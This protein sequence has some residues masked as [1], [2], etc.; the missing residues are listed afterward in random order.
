MVMRNKENDTQWRRAKL[1]AFA[2]RLNRDV[3][4]DV[5]DQLEKQPNV[6]QYLIKLVREDIKKEG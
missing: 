4:Q 3:E 2:L 1:R 6:R 5:I